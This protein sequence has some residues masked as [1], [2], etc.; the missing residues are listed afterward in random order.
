MGLLR[1]I[2]KVREFAVLSFRH[3]GY[4]KLGDRW[5]LFRV[6]VALY[7]KGKFRPNRELTQR[8]WNYKLTSDSPKTLFFLFQEIF[9]SEVYRFSSETDTPRILDAG[10]NIGLA[11]CYFKMNYPNARIAVIEPAPKAMDY[12]KKNVSQN[13]FQDVELIEAALSDRAGKEEFWTAESLLNSSLY[14]KEK[15]GQSLEVRGIRLSDLLRDAAYDLVKLDIEGAER[16]V[17]Q[18][19]QASGLIRKAKT[20]I[21][22]YHRGDG[23]EDSYEEVLDLFQK[24]GFALKKRL[25]SRQEPVEE[26]LHF[27]RENGDLGFGD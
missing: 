16:K 1:F 26:I 27:E 18:D 22:E 10:A 8:L 2:G 17:L 3:P 9:V 24:S 11:V 5:E 14:P 23:M 12:L 13:Q 6:Q 7:W 19:L 25:L 4:R 20:Y 15:K 21:L